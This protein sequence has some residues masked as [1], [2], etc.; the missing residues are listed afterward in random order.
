MISA[1]ATVN[2]MKLLLENRALYDKLRQMDADD[3]LWRQASERVAKKPKLIFPKFKLPPSEGQFLPSEGTLAERIE[4]RY[5]TLTDCGKNCSFLMNGEFGHP[6]SGSYARILKAV[7]ETKHK[8]NE[9]LRVLNWLRIILLNYATSGN[10]EA[11]QLSSPIEHAL[12]K[13]AITFIKKV[14]AYES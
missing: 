2:D 14:I 6:V 1:D 7:L 12:Y 3:E 5:N 9:E 4:R 13:S 11:A 10:M 8:N